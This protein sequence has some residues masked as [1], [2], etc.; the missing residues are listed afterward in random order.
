MT[1]MHGYYD[2]KVVILDRPVSVPPE[3]EVLV[4]FQDKTQKTPDEMKAVL[5]QLRGSAQGLNLVDKLLKDR[6]QDG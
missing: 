6:K 4:I 3:T 5:G 2:G 1:A